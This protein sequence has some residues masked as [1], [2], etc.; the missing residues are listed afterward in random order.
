[1]SYIMSNNLSSK[2]HIRQLLAAHDLHAK[3]HFG[4]NFLTD[5]HVLSKIVAAAELT[6]QDLVIEVGP[7]L[8]V[9]T[10][11]MAAAA[12]HI[13]AIEID[14][15]LADILRAT[16]PPNVEIVREDIL[17]ADVASIIET[18]GHTTAKVVA[19]LPYY[20]TTPVIFGLLEQGLPISKMVVMVQKEVADRFLAAPGTKAYGIPTLSLQFYGKASLV[21][22]VPPHS[23]FPRPD[24][25]SAVIKVEIDPI[26]DINPK[27]FFPLVRAAFS[28]RRKTLVNCLAAN[29]NLNLTK[30]KA[31]E[32]LEKAALRPD[33]RGEALSFEHFSHL[34]KL[35]SD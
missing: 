34:T 15:Q 2:N 10:A 17:K 13:A 27:I 35:L 25:H 33:I 21:A 26:K 24:V 20:I 1:M 7:G 30:Q 9:L 31:A 22:N 8:G 12:G 4:Q 16:M 11:E 18:S 3:K 32:L 23:F 29:D 28:N 19:N 6:P 5:A 14:S